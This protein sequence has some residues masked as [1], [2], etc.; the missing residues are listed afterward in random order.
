[1]SAR[2]LV[3]RRT[4]LLLLVLWLALVA[5]SFIERRLRSQPASA[6]PDSV[7][8]PFRPGTERPLTVQKGL[9]LTAPMGAL[10][11]RIAASELVQYDSGWDEY[12]NV[13]GSLFNER[14]VS[15]GLT[16]ER[17][18]INTA[19]SRA[20]I[21]GEAQLALPGGITLRADG[22]ELR[23]P[24]P[25]LES[26]AAVTF[27]GPGWGGLAEHA[28]F[29]LA[30]DLLELAG[31]ISVSWRQGSAA[32][33]SAVVL[34][35]SKMIYKRR[36]A[37]LLFPDG[38]TALSGNLGLRS[39]RA[40]LQLAQAEGELRRVALARPVVLD[41]FADDGSRV[42]GEAGE[43]VVE[44][45]ADRRLRFVAESTAAGWVWLRHQGIDG[46]RRLATWQ[47]IGE[48]SQ[49]A[50]EWIEGKGLACGADLGT[51]GDER[52]IEAE[53][54][55]ATFDAGRPSIVTATGNVESTIAQRKLSGH[56]LTYSVSLGT[57]SLTAAADG[58]VSVTGAD[59]QATCDQIEGSGA[60]TVTAIGQVSGR[61]IRGG[62]G[63]G[64][65][66]GEAVRFAAQRV[67]AHTDGSRVLLDGEG[68]IWQA[69]RLISADS[70]ELD[71]RTEVVVA[72]GHVLTS[73]PLARPQA[74]K[75][76]KVLIRSTQ[77]NYDRRGGVAIY[78][79][80]VSLED[81]RARA[82]CQR[83]VVRLDGDGA[84][85]KA[86]LDAGVTLVDLSSPRQ[87]RG[88]RAIYQVRQDLFD[89][90]GSPVVVQEP[91]GNQVR[92]E[93]LQWHRSTD[94]VVITGGQDNPSETLYHPQ[95]PAPKARP[96]GQ[97]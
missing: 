65:S 20:E 35:A 15:Y 90:W 53:Q 33:D 80:D 58:R 62:P 37:L 82:S 96:R 21:T 9:T 60:S 70:I 41:G 83:L 39:P 31:G 89:L 57:F 66:R 44:V 56:E 25:T 32:S 7:A 2:A 38:L 79:G 50:W 3:V 84:V 11:V 72:R 69:E 36:Q 71:Q 34:L 47:M 63:P 30:D 24:G 55:R 29:S 95:T 77:L 67:T 51:S 5:G 46:E 74:T 68:R 78:E 22:F 1:M 61:L 91:S 94:T 92:A 14:G 81:P 43:V 85:T 6:S 76:D 93:H 8:P 88:E 49:T 54:V 75:S 4:S 28:T 42:D 18:R 87:L 17:A 19:Q 86:E 27:A 45:M 16:A 73:S 23:P 48:G 13:E 97:K 10:K 59:L 64:S 12:R 52:R 40:E 26:T